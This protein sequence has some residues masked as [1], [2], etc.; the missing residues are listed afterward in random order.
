MRVK[1][2]VKHD[3]E[4]I[5][6]SFA[7][8]TPVK[9]G[10]NCTHFIGWC[11]CVIEGHNTYLPHIFVE[12]GKLL[13]DYNPTELVQDIGDILIVQEIVHSWLLATNESG[14]KGWIPAESV[15]SVG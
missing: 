5:F 2:V 7:A 9:I 8:G 6:P 3:G 15:V 1:L 13:R 11:A 14:E 4:G 10:E 12:N